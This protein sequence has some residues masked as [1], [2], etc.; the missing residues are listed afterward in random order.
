VSLRFHWSLSAVGDTMRR[1]NARRHER[2][3]G[4]GRTQ[5][6][7]PGRAEEDGIESAA[8]RSFG[9]WRIRYGRP[10]RWNSTDAV[11]FLVAVRSG[12]VSPTYF[13]Q[14][15]NT[16]SALTGGRVCVNVV[17]GRAPDEQR[18]LW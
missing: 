8:G 10:L 5:A 11:K 14:Q 13:V 17:A 16:L 6:L 9:L 18:F 2:R 12:V 15:V 1:A 7:L 4:L 3:A